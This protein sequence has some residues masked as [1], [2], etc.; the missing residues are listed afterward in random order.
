MTGLP[1]WSPAKQCSSL[2][3]DPMDYSSPAP[4]LGFLRQNIGMGCHFHSPRD[5]PNRDITWVS[6]WLTDSLS[7]W[8]TR[9]PICH[10]GKGLPAMQEVL[11]T[12][13]SI[14][15]HAVQ[16]SQTW[17]NDW[18]CMHACSVLTF[19]RELVV[20]HYWYITGH[21]CLCIFY[22]WLVPANTLRT[23]FLTIG[24]QGL[25]TKDA[26]NTEMYMGPLNQKFWEFRWMLTFQQ[27]DLYYFFFRKVKLHVSLSFQGRNQK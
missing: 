14:P 12:M 22:N 2:L 15:V 27:L 17:L 25:K 19:S 1:Q 24:P 26:R 18:A 23:Q 9:K 10:S 11:K 6:C 13:A 5:L 8:A 16:R 7:T 4:H 20:K 3:C 21:I